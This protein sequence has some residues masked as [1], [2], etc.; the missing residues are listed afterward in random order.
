[1]ARI[2]IFEKK[3]PLKAKPDAWICM[4]GVSRNFPYCDGSHSRANLE[5]E[6]E[7]KLYIYD[8]KLKRKRVKIK[9]VE[10]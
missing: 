7:G 4:C 9:E 10:K 3:S 1:M 8:E 6:K 5:E 2:R